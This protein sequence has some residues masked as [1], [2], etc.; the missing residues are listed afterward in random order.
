MDPGL[1]IGLSAA[2]GAEAPLK[3]RGISKE[4]AAKAV[5]QS[6]LSGLSRRNQHAAIDPI[7]VLSPG[8]AVFFEIRFEIIFTFIFLFSCAKLR[9]AGRPRRLLQPFCAF[10]KI[11]QPQEASQPLH[12]P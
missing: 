12:F 8:A 4:H 7:K 3:K 2:S 5:L 1:G 9:E 10:R 11:V 6:F